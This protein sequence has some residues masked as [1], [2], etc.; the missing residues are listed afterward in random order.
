MQESIVFLVCVQCRRKESLRSLSHLP[1]SFLS[2][3][4]APAYSAADES[5]LVADNGQ[6]RTGDVLLA[7]PSAAVIVP[8][9][10]LS[11]GGGKFK[12]AKS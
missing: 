3:L 2:R 12:D 6:R 11:R 5:N 7:V 9:R 8:C 4:Q 1:M 10:F